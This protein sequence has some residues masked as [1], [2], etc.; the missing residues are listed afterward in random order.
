MGCFLQQKGFSDEAIECCLKKENEW[1]CNPPLDE[2]EINQIIKSSLHYNKGFIGV[3]NSIHYE[4]SYTV[5]ELL[6][7]KIMMNL[8]SWKI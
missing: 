5:E 3:R 4:G 7:S 1:K 6:V 8:I 2:K